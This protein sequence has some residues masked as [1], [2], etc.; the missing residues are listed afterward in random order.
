MPKLEKFGI[1]FIRNKP[2]PTSQEI[3]SILLAPNYCKEWS[4]TG[5]LGLTIVSRS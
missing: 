3:A 4:V 5:Y 1:H 2:T